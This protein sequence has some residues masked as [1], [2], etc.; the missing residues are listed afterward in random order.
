MAFWIARIAAVIV[1]LC[2]AAALA[3]PRGRLPLALRGAYMVMRRD[4]GLPANGGGSEEC[5][6]PAWRRVAAFA[7]VLA[8]AAAAIV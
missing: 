4:R 8:A 3:T 6:V 1:L 7:L 2:V 5:G